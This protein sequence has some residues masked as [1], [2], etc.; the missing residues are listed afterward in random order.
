MIVS[1]T[2]DYKV[3]SASIFFLEHN[4]DMSLWD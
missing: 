1:Q 2:F 3:V 4:I